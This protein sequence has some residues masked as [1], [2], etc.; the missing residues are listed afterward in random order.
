MGPNEHNAE[1]IK[2][3]IDNYILL[4]NTVLQKNYLSYFHLKIYLL[5]YVVLL[6]IFLL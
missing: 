2:R 5:F 3:N 1:F 4:I 6:K